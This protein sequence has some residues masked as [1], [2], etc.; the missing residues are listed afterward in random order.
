MGDDDIMIVDSSPHPATFSVPVAPPAPAPSSGPVTMDL[1][2]VA[3]VIRNPSYAVQLPRPTAQDMKEAY[4]ALQSQLSAV[5]SG[6]MLAAMPNPTAEV[7]RDALVI[8]IMSNLS[9][10]ALPSVM[11]QE[12]QVYYLSDP[13]AEAMARVVSQFYATEFLPRPSQQSQAHDSALLVQLRRTYQEVLSQRPRGA[14]AAYL[15]TLASFSASIAR[16][17]VTATGTGMQR[18]STGRIVAL[19]YRHL[20]QIQLV[21]RLFPP[22]QRPGSLVPRFDLSRASR[23]A[24]HNDVDTQLVRVLREHFAEPMPFVQAL[25]AKGIGALGHRLLRGMVQLLAWARRKRERSAGL[26]SMVVVWDGD[27]I[28]MTTELA[29]LMRGPWFDLHVHTLPFT[30]DGWQAATRSMP[31]VT[32]HRVDR[33]FKEAT[34][35]EALHHLLFNLRRVAPHR[36]ILLVSRDRSFRIMESL[37]NR[38]ASGA[39]AWIYCATDP[40]EIEVLAHW[41]TLCLTSLLPN[42]TIAQWKGVKE[43]QGPPF[44][45]HLAGAEGASA[46]TFHECKR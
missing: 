40:A 35:Y 34:D 38:W 1:I 4:Q 14:Q 13:A 43:V 15:A 46:S 42:P 16:Y 5:P 12:F 18:T 44:A 41:T 31:Y 28:S 19:D 20:A 11:E 3:L 36:P 21:A 17:N 29:R 2:H 7:M 6:C 37:A 8:L 45:H 32:L 23:Y 10:N 39:A 25:R 9:D 24:P 27:N 30:M 26:S 33:T 22:N